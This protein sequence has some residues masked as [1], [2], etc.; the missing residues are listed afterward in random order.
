[1]PAGSEVFVNPRLKS[2]FGGPPS[3]IQLSTLPFGFFT[4]RCIHVWGLIHSVRVI[5]PFN[6]TGFFASN[7][8]ANP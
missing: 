2:A 3:I 8:A 7:S 1:M 6:L 4:A 5:V